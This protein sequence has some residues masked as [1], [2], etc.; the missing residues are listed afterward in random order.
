[1]LR[2]KVAC[3]LFL[4]LALVA[5]KKD[6]RRYAVGPASIVVPE[7]FLDDTERAAKLAGKGP[8]DAQSR[9]WANKVSKLQLALSLARLPHQPD[10]EK[11][12]TQVLLFEM[13]SQEKE[14]GEKAGLK[15]VDWSKEMK[16]DVLHY[17]IDGDMQGKLA[18][19]A[20]TVL[21][22]DAKGDCWHASAVCTSQPADR[23]QCKTLMET[24]K[25]DVASFDA[26]GPAP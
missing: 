1:M 25:F 21:W 26:G 13:F 6:E 15:T 24:V 12:S 14:A 2:R 7:G 10:W 8:I 16:G 9:V 22:V 11:V 18:T 20:R 5:C 17:A 23:A 4:L 3:P 19:T